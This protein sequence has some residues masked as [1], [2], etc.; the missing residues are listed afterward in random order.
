[1]DIIFCGKRQDKNG[2]SCYE[3]GFQNVLN[4][5]VFSALNSHQPPEY[6]QLNFYKDEKKPFEKKDQKRRLQDFE[7]KGLAEISAYIKKHPFYTIRRAS[8][9]EKK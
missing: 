5:K 7:H 4:I 1:M 3:G 2:Y 9:D 6:F 8:C